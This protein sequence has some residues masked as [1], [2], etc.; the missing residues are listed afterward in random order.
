[1]VVGRLPGGVLLG[2]RLELA[3]ELGVADLERHLGS[4]AP[5]APAAGSGDQLH[6]GLQAEAAD[7]VE[8]GVAD[9]G[10]VIGSSPSSPSK[11]S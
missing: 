11:T 1:L 9:L 6:L 8:G 4:L 7:I 3:R 2:D 5:S 10:V